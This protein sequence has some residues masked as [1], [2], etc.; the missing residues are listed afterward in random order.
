MTL[1]RSPDGGDVD[2]RVKTKEHKS[3]NGERVEVV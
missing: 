2:R 1:Q 3:T